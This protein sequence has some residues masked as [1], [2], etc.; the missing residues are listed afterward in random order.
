MCRTRCRELG[1]N[2][3]EA[4]LRGEGVARVQSN[5]FEL[6]RQRVSKAV[7]IALGNA[8]TTFDAGTDFHD[9]G[10][11]ER[12]QRVTDRGAADT[13]LERQLMLR[14]DRIA[15]MKTSFEQCVAELS[16]DFIRGADGSHAAPDA[17]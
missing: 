13:E 5:K 4:K 16:D 3:F 15:G 17:R 6:D 11:F 1:R 8:D 9:A 7:R 12:P 14:A 10:R 2:P